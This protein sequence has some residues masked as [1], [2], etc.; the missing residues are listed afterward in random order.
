M[1]QEAELLFFEDPGNLRR[2]PGKFGVLYLLRRDINRCME[3][4]AEILWPGAMAIL[5]GIDL[6]AKFF[7]GEDRSQV[8]T[9]FFK[10]IDKYFILDAEGNRVI[11]QF[12]NALLHSFGLYSRTNSGQIYRFQLVYRC[13]GPLVDKVGPDIF[14]IDLA[15]LHESFESA[16]TRYRSDLLT[17][18]DLQ[19]KFMRML[20]DYGAINISA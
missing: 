18:C 5:A 13:F 19:S 6:M 15:R 8:G 2:P 4:N 16:V 12:R 1:D 3:P 7:A 9:R 14:R 10:F 20:P 11:Y 17:D